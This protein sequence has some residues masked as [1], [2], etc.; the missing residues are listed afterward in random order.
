MLIA[1]HDSRETAGICAGASL[2]T[3]TLESLVLL[4]SLSYGGQDR[5]CSTE[6]VA[7]KPEFGSRF[8]PTRLAVQKAIGHYSE[9]KGFYVDNGL[10]RGSSV[11]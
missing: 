4:R 10:V 5:N 2:R 9:G 8:H 1:P 11:S 6:G 3:G 7:L